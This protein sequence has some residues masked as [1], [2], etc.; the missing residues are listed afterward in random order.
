MSN[1]LNELKVKITSTEVD[2]FSGM[3]KAGRPFTIR[4]QPALLY[5]PGDPDPFRFSIRLDDHQQPYSQGHY[6]IDMTSVRVDRF[7]GLEFGPLKLSPVADTTG[8][9]KAA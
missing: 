3:T 6:I 5:L 1:E 8:K 2:E 4:K 9:V 7:G